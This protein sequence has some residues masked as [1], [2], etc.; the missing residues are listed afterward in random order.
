MKEKVILTTNG[1][2]V[3]I[4]KV[5]TGFEATLTFFRA[6]CK[7]GVFQTPYTSVIAAMSAFADKFE[8]TPFPYHEVEQAALRFLR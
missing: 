5:E 6:E 7:G 4:E 8:D 1:V 3:E 2:K